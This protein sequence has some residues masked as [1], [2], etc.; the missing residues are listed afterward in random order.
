MTAKTVSTKQTRA[1]KTRTRKAA[2]KAAPRKTVF[3]QFGDTVI[4]LP[5]K[6]AS[7]TFLA[8]LGLLSYMQTEVE[9]Q[10]R[11][12]DRKLDKYAKDGEKVLDR[13]EHRVGSL[14]KDV[15][16]RVEDVRGRVRN[17]FEKAA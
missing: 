15:E 2:P 12:F 14:R 10:Y 6:A 5:L 17:T 3:D 8:S 4:V 16:K 13:F 9:K 1:A 11:E 7:K